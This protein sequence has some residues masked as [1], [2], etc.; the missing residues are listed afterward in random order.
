MSWISFLGLFVST[1]E[2]YLNRTRN[3]NAKTGTMHTR[4]RHIHFICDLCL[5][6]S[7]HT[8]SPLWTFVFTQHLFGFIACVLRMNHFINPWSSEGFYWNILR[9]ISHIARVGNWF[10]CSTNIFNEL[11]LSVYLNIFTCGQW[12]PTKYILQFKEEKNWKCTFA[13]ITPWLLKKRNV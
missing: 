11:M 10:N 8:I 6:F 13:N 7:I 1:F 5:F 4:P 12:L 9:A 2:R 3:F